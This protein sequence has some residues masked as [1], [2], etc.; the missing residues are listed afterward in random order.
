MLSFIKDLFLEYRIG[1]ALGRLLSEPNRD[2]KR[3]H[4]ADMATLIKRRSARR[5]EQMERKAGL[6]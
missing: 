1:R 2:I 5:V 3:K 4:A 6:R